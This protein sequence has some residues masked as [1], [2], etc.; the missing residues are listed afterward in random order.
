M[1]WLAFG[2]QALQPFGRERETSF[3]WAGFDPERSYLIVALVGAAALFVVLALC[4]SMAR[5]IPRRVS[6][7]VTL[8]GLWVV[9]I[10]GC[11]FVGFGLLAAASNADG[12]YTEIEGDTLTRDLVV[13]EW[14][15]LFA[16]G[17]TVFERDGAL[18]TVVGS[19]STDDGYMPL[20]EGTYAATEEEGVVTLR[21]PFHSDGPLDSELTIKP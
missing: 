2:A 5:R 20:A 3:L 9:L 19:V 16:G 12:M 1:A 17:G 13:R 10:A 11:P 6:R 21:W 4:I 8:A 15:F 14:S 18:L 7:R